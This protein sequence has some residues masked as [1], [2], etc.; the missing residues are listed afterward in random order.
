MLA[1]WLYYDMAL[2]FHLEKVYAFFN[3]QTQRLQSIVIFAFIK[4]TS[5]KDQFFRNI[6]DKA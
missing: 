1:I 3:Q 4:K 6:S 5:C 2:F